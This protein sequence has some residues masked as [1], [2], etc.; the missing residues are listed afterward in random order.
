MQ[1]QGTEKMFGEDLGGRLTAVTFKVSANESVLIQ[2]GDRMAQQMEG[3]SFGLP[4]S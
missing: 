3:R 4:S 1:R 2:W